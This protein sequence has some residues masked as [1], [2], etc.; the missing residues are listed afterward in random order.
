M[1][2]NKQSLWAIL[3]HQNWI[4]NS[5]SKSIACNRQFS[6][7]REQKRFQGSTWLVSWCSVFHLICLTHSIEMNLQLCYK[8]WNASSTLSQIDLL[9]SCLRMLQWRFASG[10]TLREVKEAKKVK[11]LFLINSFPILKLFTLTK[12]LMTSLKRKLRSV[13]CY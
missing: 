10:L 5:N 11:Q 9:N 7:K 1:D 6:K 12:N 2:L 13:T 4:L 8:L 3:L